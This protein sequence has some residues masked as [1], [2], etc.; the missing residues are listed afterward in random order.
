MD[1]GGI[2]AI[3][4]DGNN[5]FV[6]KIGNMNNTDFYKTTSNV[7]KKVRAEYPDIVKNAVLDRNSIESKQ[8]A[9]LLVDGLVDELVKL[10]EIEYIKYQ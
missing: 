7:A 10:K 5:Y 6:K 2:R 8:L 9:Q 4:K 3:T 1:F